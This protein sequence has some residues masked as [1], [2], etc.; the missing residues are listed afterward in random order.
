MRGDFKCDIGGSKECKYVS[1]KRYN[2]GIA[3]FCNK[4]KKFIEDMKRCPK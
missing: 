4:A 1:Q 2:H 3:G